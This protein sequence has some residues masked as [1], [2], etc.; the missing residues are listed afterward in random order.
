MY[1]SGKEARLWCGAVQS[2]QSDHSKDDAKGNTGMNGDRG[3]V[4]LA[5]PDTQRRVRYV[6]GAVVVSLL[7]CM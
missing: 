5:G 4:G 2:Q 6:S 7:F 1:K 3:G